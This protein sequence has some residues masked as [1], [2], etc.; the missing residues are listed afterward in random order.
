MGRYKNW[1]G[2]IDKPILELLTF[3][4][5]LDFGESDFGSKTI[6]VDDLRMFCTFLRMFC[7]FFNKYCGKGAV[8]QSAASA[9]SLRG[10]RASG[11][12]DHGLFFRN[13]WPR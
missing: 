4:R 10:G 13:F 12:L 1:R 9:A 7:V 8:N 6:H 11:R 3:G 5:N 2:V